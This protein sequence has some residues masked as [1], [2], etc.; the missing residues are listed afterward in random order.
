MNMTQTRINLCWKLFQ[1]G[2]V[3]CCDFESFW[4]IFSFNVLHISFVQCALI[5]TEKETFRKRK[6]K[7]KTDN[8]NEKWA[9]LFAIVWYVLSKTLLHLAVLLPFFYFSRGFFLASRGFVFRW[10]HE[11][12]IKFSNCKHCDWITT[13]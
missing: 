13:I 10:I 6:K 4:N 5:K 2:F 1:F 7:E 12:K 9:L 11:K 8:D 3:W